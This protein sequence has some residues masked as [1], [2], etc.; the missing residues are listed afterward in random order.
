VATDTWRERIAAD[1][2]VPVGKPVIKGTRLTVALILELL[3]S[4]WT[5]DRILANYTDITAEDVRACIAYA[6]EVLQEE[7]VLLRA[8]QETSLGFLADEPDIYDD[9]DGEPV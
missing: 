2:A 3:A 5:F 8:S 4:G 9:S 7:R 1:P 6:K